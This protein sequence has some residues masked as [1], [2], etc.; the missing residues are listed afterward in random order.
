MAKSYKP[1]APE[2]PK[3]EA[4]KEQPPMVETPKVILVR[5]KFGLMVDL[6]GSQYGQE[7]KVVK[8]ITPWMQSQIN[9]GKMEVYH[10]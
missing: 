3:A 10:G 7:P 6:D 9:A 4:P 5:A 1:E 2:A 8:E